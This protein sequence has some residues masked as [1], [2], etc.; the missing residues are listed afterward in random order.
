MKRVLVC[1]LALLMLTA[2]AACDLRNRKDSEDFFPEESDLPGWNGFDSPTNQQEKQSDEAVVVKTVMEYSGDLPY[3]SPP[4]EYSYQLPMIDLA[5]AQAVGCNQEIENVFGT[6]IR[7]SMDAI[8]EYQTPI[9]AQLSYSY[10]VYSGILTLRVLR[11]DTDGQITT[12]YY[13]VNAKNGEAVSLAEL[14]RTAGISGTPDTV[15]NDAL[16]ERFTSRFGKLEGADP[17]VTTA[18]NQTQ[19]EL[20]PLSPNRMYIT[21]DG[22]LSVRFMLYAPNGGSSIEEI[23]LP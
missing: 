3:S 9:L 13:T 2:L 21:E 8:Q 7:Q 1:L 11:Q 15:V 12:A 4:Q 5:G 23:I 10:Y 17:A 22:R 14:F 18:L 6:L 20:F 19:A 16:L